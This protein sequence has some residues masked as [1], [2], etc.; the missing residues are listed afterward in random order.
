M[1][2]PFSLAPKYEK[3]RVSLEEALADDLYKRAAVPAVLFI[4][5]LY[6]YY[7]VLA[8]AVTRRPA[9]GWIFV[10]MSLL[11]FPR[12]LSILRAAQIKRRFPN[13]RT[14]IELFALGSATYGTCW[15]ALNLTAA[16]VITAEELAL[17][18]VTTAGI[19]AS[20]MVG[21]NASVTS[22]LFSVVPNVASIIVV[23]AIGPPMQNRTM[24]VVIMSVFLLTLIL[25]S[26]AMHVKGRNALL[27]QIQIAEA[28]ANMQ[29][30]HLQLQAEV[31]ER[32]A[33]EHALAQRNHE[34]EQLNRELTD[35][36]S[37][38]LQS[39]KMASVGQ[40]AAGVAHEINNPIAFVRSNL[41]TLKGYMESILA[42]IETVRTASGGAAEVEA[43]ELEFLREDIP[44]L[45]EESIEGAT[46][47]EKIV[48]D[49]KEF[50]H[51]DEAEWQ[52]VDLHAGLETTLNVAAHEIKYK[53]EVI[54]DYG[55]LPLVECLPFQI[56]QVFLNLLVNA[57]HAID[58]RG[59]ITVRTG[60]DE[61]VAW[62]QVVDTGRGIE[63]AV[64]H[65]IFEPFFTTKPVGVG[66]GLGLSVSYGIVQ[67]HGGTIEVA[68]KVGVGSIF[69]VRLPIRGHRT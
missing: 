22:Y 69:T 45:L 26:I 15:A 23:G 9:L 63:P 11:L 35:T 56:N 20:G 3:Y 4:P 61:D 1:R 41:H 55:E 13:P 59:T 12:V 38:L 44:S 19:T 47:V 46:R 32:V 21:M 52:K 36:Q 28:Y 34:L 64:V 48:K 60:V 62:V 14:R 24:F 58:S 57:A 49:L 65:R 18:A 33:A 27:L 42:G 16:P 68:S 51:V 67:K 53:A 7:L 6:L 39:E 10:L 8:E 37:Q 30:A 50:S 17:M 40:L 54:R 29:E 31:A 66:T 2:N 43:A 25:I 5:G